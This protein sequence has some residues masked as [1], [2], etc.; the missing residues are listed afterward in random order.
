MNQTNTYNIELNDTQ[1]MQEYR[2]DKFFVNSITDKCK[3]E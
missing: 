1:P 3:L 2:L